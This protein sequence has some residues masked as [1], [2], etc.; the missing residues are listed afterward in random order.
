[1]LVVF[2]VATVVHLADDSF[3]RYSL[4]SRCYSGFLLRI[5]SLFDGVL[6]DDS[7][8]HS[9]SSRRYSGFLAEDLWW[10]SCSC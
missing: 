1:M 9:L 5:S 4:S 6:V 2:S 7:F 8:L 3:L 10:R